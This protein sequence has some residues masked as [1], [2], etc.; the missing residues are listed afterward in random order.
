M[1]SDVSSKAALEKSGIMISGWDSRNEHDGD[2]AKSR[3]V[4]SYNALDAAVILKET[5]GMTMTVVEN[6]GNM[7][8]WRK[9]GTIKKQ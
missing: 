7:C 5:W 8:K 2:V 9:A 3:V 1:R 4:D 6:N